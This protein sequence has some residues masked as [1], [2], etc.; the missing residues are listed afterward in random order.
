M[1][2]LRPSSLA[3]LGL[4]MPTVFAQQAGTFTAVGS[5]LVSALM[6]MFLAS[7]FSLVSDR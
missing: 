5:T 1:V 7:Y 3:L 2:L 6:V 4:A